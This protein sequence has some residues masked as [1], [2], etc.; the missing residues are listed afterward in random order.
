MKILCY[1]HKSNAI[2]LR[3]NDFHW[4]IIDYARIGY[5]VDEIKKSLLLVKASQN[6]RNL[7]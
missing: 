5:I 2:I 3:N 1:K 4:G 6:L 7:G